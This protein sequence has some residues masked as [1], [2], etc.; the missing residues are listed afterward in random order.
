MKNLIRKLLS[1]CYSD[2]KDGAAETA[3]SIC[4]RD[5]AVQIMMYYPEC[6]FTYSKIQTL[7]EVELRLDKYLHK[8]RLYLDPCMNLTKMAMIVGSNRTYL[9]NIMASRNGFRNYMNELRLKYIADRIEDSGVSGAK[10][11]LREPKEKL[12]SDDI[13][14][15]VLSSGFADMRTFR[16]ALSLSVGKWADVIREKIY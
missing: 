8:E 10:K 3:P 6:S 14:S 16:R 7:K 15:I 9:S 13:I 11:C 4:E 1:H 2:G 5:A 12:T